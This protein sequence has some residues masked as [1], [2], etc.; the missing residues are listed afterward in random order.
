V[1]RNAKGEGKK[2]KN[3]GRA[4][5]ARIS[6]NLRETRMREARLRK[7]HDAGRAYEKVELL[8]MIKEYHLG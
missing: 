2:K 5:R 8:R 3:R 6:G 1:Q 4:A 7:T